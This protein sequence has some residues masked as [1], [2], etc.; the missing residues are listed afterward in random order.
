V[1]KPVQH[2]P[3]MLIL[4]WD[5]VYQYVLPAPILQH[6]TN[7]CN[8]TNLA[9]HAKILRQTVQV[10]HRDI[11]FLILVLAQDQI[12]DEIKIIRIQVYVYE[13]HHNLHRTVLPINFITQ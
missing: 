1:L 10:V 6:R 12:K 9:Q 4:I 13:V 11:S 2:V 7:A 5:N 3:Q 8:A